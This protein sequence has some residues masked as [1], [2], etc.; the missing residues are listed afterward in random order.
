MLA[1]CARVTAESY[2]KLKLGMGFD[3]VRAILGSPDR[4]SDV[5]G[6]KPCVW[7][8]EVRNI[9]VNLIGDKTV[10]FTAENLR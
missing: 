1:G 4:C 7:G 5:L 10:L 2:A 6:A 8:D 9:Q 3:Q